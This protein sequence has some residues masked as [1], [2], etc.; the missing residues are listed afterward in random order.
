MDAGPL[1]PTAVRASFALFV[2]VVVLSLLNA[3]IQISF[4]IS[5]ATVLV[6]ALIEA[7]LFLV[8]GSQ[9]R[10]GRLW[11]RVT[12]MSVAWV[13]VAVS[14]LALFGLKGEFGRNLDGLVLFTLGYVT[15]KLAMI[16]AA[17]VL[18]YRPSTRGYFH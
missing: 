6:G 9:M 8:L 13:F 12:L 17:T 2:G 1:P 10:V 11:A 7:A 15:A 5:G 14:L 4:R 16:V 18:M 3:V